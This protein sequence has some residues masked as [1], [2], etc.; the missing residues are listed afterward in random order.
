MM[1]FLAL[2]TI[3][4][5]KDVFAQDQYNLTLEKQN[6]IYFSRRGKNFNDEQ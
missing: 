2:I 1:L 4:S 5:V 6:G 3:F